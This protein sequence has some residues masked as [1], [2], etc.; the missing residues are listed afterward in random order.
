MWQHA[1]W[2]ATTWLARRS[3]AISAGRAGQALANVRSSKT[4]CVPFSSRDSGPDTA[5]S[6]NWQR[7]FARW[8]FTRPCAASYWHRISRLQTSGDRGSWTGTAESHSVDIF[9]EDHRRRLAGFSFSGLPDAQKKSRRGGTPSG[10]PPRRL[11]YYQAPR[12]QFGQPSCSLFSHPTTCNSQSQNFA[13]GTQNPPE[14]YS[15]KWPQECKDAFVFV[16]AESQRGWIRRGFQRCWPGTLPAMPP[17]TLIAA[18]GENGHINPGHRLRT[19]ASCG[20]E[21]CHQCSDTCQ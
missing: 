18:C 15:I 7:A 4:P 2:F 5:E 14:Q 1:D 11:T 16:C 9:R 3:A 19:R 8:P 12:R 21:S 13:A 20:L 10:I 17:R 6:V